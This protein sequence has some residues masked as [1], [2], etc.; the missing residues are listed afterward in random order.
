MFERN[1]HP[2]AKESAAPCPQNA[3]WL[4][5]A[6]LHQFWQGWKV[7][8]K[9]ID[10]R[11]LEDDGKQQGV[12][13]DGFVGIIGNNLDIERIDLI[14]QIGCIDGSVKYKSEKRV[15]KDC[16]ELC[17]SWVAKGT[18]VVEDEEEEGEEGME[19]EVEVEFILKR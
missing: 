9:G 15:A 16:A 4:W 18:T 8:A 1:R 2:I 12:K 7:D 3:E 19:M 10:I 13:S 14:I 11:K 5:Q 6:N 17:Q